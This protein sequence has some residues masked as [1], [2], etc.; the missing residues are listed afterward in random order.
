M[1]ESFVVSQCNTEMSKMA[2]MAKN[3]SPEFKGVIV[4]IVCVV[5]F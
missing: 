1:V 3:H 5:E 2:K 4:Q